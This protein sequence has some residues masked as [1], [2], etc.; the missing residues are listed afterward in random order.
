MEGLSL[1]DYACNYYRF[2][3]CLY[4]DSFFGSVLSGRRALLS[5]RV[6]MEGGAAESRNT[7]RNN[8]IRNRNFGRDFY[9]C[10]V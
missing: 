6:A 2:L 5:G 7:D 4:A 8:T 3:Y 10:I 1:L 9:S